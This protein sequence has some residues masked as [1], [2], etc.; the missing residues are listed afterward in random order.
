VLR[1]LKEGFG[2][3]VGDLR[4]FIKSVSRFTESISI[5]KAG[6]LWFHSS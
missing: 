3:K 4:S 2:I 1:E 6:G 5:L